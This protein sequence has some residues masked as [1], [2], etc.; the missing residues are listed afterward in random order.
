[1]TVTVKTIQIDPK[2]EQ[3]IK[4]GNYFDKSYTLNKFELL[5]EE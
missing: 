2:E 1:M 4:L 5:T 3:V